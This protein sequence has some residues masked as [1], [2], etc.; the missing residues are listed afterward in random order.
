[1]EKRKK[2]S[3]VPTKSHSSNDTQWKMVVHDSW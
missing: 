2:R 3:Y 1:M